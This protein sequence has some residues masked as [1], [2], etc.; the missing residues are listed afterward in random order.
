[1]NKILVFFIGTVLLQ[2]LCASNAN[3]NVEF[4]I[5]AG[6]DRPLCQLYLERLNTTSFDEPPFCDRPERPDLDGFEKLNRVYLT[7]E[8]LLKIYNQITSFR[9]HGD[10]LRKRYLKPSSIESI[11]QKHRTHQLEA[12][13]YEP[14]VDIDNDGSPDN[15]LVWKDGRCLY[16]TRRPIANLIVI[17]DEG[18]AMID[19]AKTLAIFGSPLQHYMKIPPTIQF[20]FREGSSF[21]VIAYGGKTYFDGF[22]RYGARDNSAVN[23]RVYEHFEGESRPICDYQWKNREPA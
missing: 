19:E 1:M 12:W 9:L 5:V 13:R 20:G 15:V 7:P 18:G 22:F 16:E 21:S 2:Y 17:L 23:V 10:Q 14:R 11:R 8:E 3:E 4:S 6:G